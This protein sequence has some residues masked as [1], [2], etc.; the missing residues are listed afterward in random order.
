MPVHAGVGYNV[1]E[2]F[3]TAHN[4][5]AVRPRT[6]VR[7]V[8]VVAVL[9]CEKLGVWL[10][11]DPVAEDRFLAL[12]A[13]G[14]VGPGKDG[15]FFDVRDRLMS[16]GGGGGGGVEEA[17]GSEGTYEVPGQFVESQR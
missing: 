7:N 13:S 8:E 2:T 1:L 11:G 10:L 12:E 17:Q 5:R 15:A 6:G 3:E 9:L 14:F 4:E 16:H